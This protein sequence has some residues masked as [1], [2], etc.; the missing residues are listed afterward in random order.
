[1]TCAKYCEESVKHLESFIK[2]NIKRTHKKIKIDYIVE[3]HECSC[4]I[5]F[6][7]QVEEKR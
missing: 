6:I 7:K 4:F 5:E 3:I 1:M 2:P